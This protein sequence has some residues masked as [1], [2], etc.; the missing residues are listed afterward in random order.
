[1]LRESEPRS[2]RRDRT[3]SDGWPG[4]E[5]CRCADESWRRC[6]RASWWWWKRAKR[7]GPPSRNVTQDRW[8]D[9]DRYFD[10]AI[11]GSED[12]EALQLVVRAGAAAGLPRIQVSASQGKLLHVM[13]RAMRAQRILEIGTLAG[14]SGIWLARALPPHGVLVTIELEPKHAAVARQG[15]AR[16]GLSH[17]VDLRVG[18]AVDVLPQLDQAAPF[19]FVFIDADKVSYPAYLEW[20][21][22]LTHPGALIVADNVVRGGAVIDADSKDEAV[23]GVRELMAAVAGDDRV[24]A[25]A[26]QTVGVKGYDGL[27][28]VLRR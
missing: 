14:Y 5:L 15:F 10:Q 3:R 2:R 19:D 11:V 28:F 6:G 20:A 13:A 17:Q 26:I 27:A 8:T 16:A 7:W 25:T 12:D 22:R 24:T 4:R 21:I 9:V 18:R 1:M 23:R